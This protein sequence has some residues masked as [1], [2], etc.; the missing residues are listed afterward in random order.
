MV[1]DPFDIV[2][3]LGGKRDA[4]HFSARVSSAT[5]AAP[6]ARPVGS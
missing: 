4:R 6:A 2:G 5:D 1:E 3:N